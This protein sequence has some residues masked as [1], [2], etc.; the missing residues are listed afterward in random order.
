MLA[1]GLT[2][3]TLVAAVIPSGDAILARAKTVFRAHLRPPYVSYTLTRRDE[4]GG[5]PDFENS[6]TLKI[7]CRVADRR[8]LMRKAWNGKSYGELVGDTIAFDGYVDPGPPTADIFEGA[9]YVRATPAPLGSPDAAATALPTIGSVSVLTNVDYRVTRVTRD[10]DA[11][12]L[13]L[14]PKGD[15]L[16][17]RMDDLWVDASSYEIRRMRVRDHLYFGFGGG[18]LPEEFDVRFADRDGLPLI[19]SIHGQTQ[20]GEYGTTYTFSDIAF[21]A[22]LP[23]WYFEPKTYGSHRIDAPA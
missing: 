5:A 17:N 3:A 1:L 19:A 9:L 14:E 8:A 23:A 18:S 21:P 4:A 11:W 16:R 13:A 2:L 22:A 15:P 10:G 20:G 7:W 12:H 6:Y